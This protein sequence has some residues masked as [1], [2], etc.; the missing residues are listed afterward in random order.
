MWQGYWFIKQ[1]EDPSMADIQSNIWWNIFTR[2]PIEPH[3]SPPEC[4][5]TGGKC[6]K[7]NPR[8]NLGP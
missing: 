2:L 5:Y 6:V 8:Q 3:F 4:K 1:G 7:Y